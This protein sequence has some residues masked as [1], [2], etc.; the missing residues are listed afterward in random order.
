M[1]PPEAARATPSS[2]PAVTAP[3]KP[4]SI[5]AAVTGMRQGGMR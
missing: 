5:A 4:T 2:G 3:K 1:P